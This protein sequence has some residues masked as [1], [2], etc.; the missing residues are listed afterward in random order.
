MDDVYSTDL[1]DND[2][3]MLD[4][5]ITA[6]NVQ[7]A[8]NMVLADDDNSNSNITTNIDL[9]PI[10]DELV[11]F[12]GNKFGEELLR[13]SDYDDI[14]V[15]LTNHWRTY[16]PECY[17]FHTNLTKGILEQRTDE[18]LFRPLD[19]FLYGTLNTDDAIKVIRSYN[20]KPTVCGRLFK[21][22]E[23]TY[24]CRDCCVDPTCVLCT[25]CFLQSEHRKHR[26]KV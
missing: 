20:K 1:S 2:E 23:P 17:M 25:D 3:F 22:E 26:Y 24:F 8:I 12:D 5:E 11:S 21:S 6:A 16:V 9:P 19:I 4:V 7:D 15:A 18:I 13:K 14:H 10:S